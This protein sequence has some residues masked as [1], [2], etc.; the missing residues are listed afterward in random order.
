[1]EVN[2]NELERQYVELWDKISMFGKVK[3]LNEEVLSYSSLLEIIEVKGVGM[4]E[5]YVIQLEFQDLQE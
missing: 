5:Y 3:L 4:I 2:L 1:M